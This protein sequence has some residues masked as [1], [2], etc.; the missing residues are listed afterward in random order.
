MVDFLRHT[1]FRAPQNA[2]EDHQNVVLTMSGG[3]ITSYSSPLEGDYGSRLIYSRHSNT[4]N[5]IPRLVL[6]TRPG[7]H[8]VRLPITSIPLNVLGRH[9]S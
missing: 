7:L 8:S 2:R 9:R 1:G 3:K 5:R 4:K 6:F